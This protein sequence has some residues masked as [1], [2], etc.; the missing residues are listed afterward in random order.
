[1]ELNIKDMT[2]G[3]IADAKAQIKAWEARQKVKKLAWKPDVGEKFWYPCADGS[4]DVDEWLDNQ[5]DNRCYEQGNVMT[6]ELAAYTIEVR[7]IIHQ[8]HEWIDENDAERGGRFIVGKSNYYIEYNADFDAL[9]I[10][11]ST[12]LI[13]NPLM[14]TF[15]TSGKLGKCINTIGEERIKL[16]FKRYD[17]A[18]GDE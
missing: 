14:P 7:A 12:E 3:Q 4:T 5:W 9:E 11:C 17:I 18:R 10:N 16:L 8:I 1:M 13:V 15:S 6:N 2:A